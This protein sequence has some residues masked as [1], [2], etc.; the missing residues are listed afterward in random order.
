MQYSKTKAGAKDKFSKAHEVSW[1]SEI[2]EVVKRVGPNSFLLDVPPGEIKVCPLHS[3]QVVKTLNA[4]LG[5]RK[6]GPVVDK[7]VVRSQRMERRN[8]SEVE[9]IAAVEAPA[10]P[11]SERAPRVDYKKL[12]SGT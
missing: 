7:K 8:I 5:E 9:A 1:T 12:A 6:E 11:R 3:L 2:Y 10:R 4:P